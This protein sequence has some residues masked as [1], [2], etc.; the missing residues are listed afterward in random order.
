M[1]LSRGS[2][3]LLLKLIDRKAREAEKEIEE[4]GTLKDEHAIPLLL[5]TQYNH[6]AHLDEEISKISKEIA[7]NRKVMAENR[8][9]MATKDDI[10]K[11][12]AIMD[13]RFN[14]MD[15]KFDTINATL[16]TNMRWT[17][18]TIIALV[19]AILIVS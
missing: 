15:S 9:V 4:T 18:T 2:E 13:A 10:K 8:K 11:I 6:I 17:I 1:K 16:I 12:Y 3:E 7:E 5:Q 19:G 14:R